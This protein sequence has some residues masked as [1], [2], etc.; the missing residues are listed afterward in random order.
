MRHQAMDD[1]GFS[2]SVSI[3]TAQNTFAR[4]GVQGTGFHVENLANNQ[5]LSFLQATDNSC[6]NDYKN[7]SS[8]R[9]ISIQPSHLLGMCFLQPARAALDRQTDQLLHLLHF[10]PSDTHLALFFLHFSNLGCYLSL[11][12]VFFFWRRLASWL[13]VDSGIV[14]LVQN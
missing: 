8:I 14:F 4:R 13:V 6:D 2:L 1:K 7:N 11:I 5:L 9:N 10:L 3:W 12:I